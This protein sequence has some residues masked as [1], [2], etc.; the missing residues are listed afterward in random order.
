MRGG[1]LKAVVLVVVS[2]LVLMFAPMAQAAEV[3]D[4]NGPELV[5]ITR[6]TGDVVSVENPTARL[7]VQATDPNGVQWMGVWVATDSTAAP[8]EWEYSSGIEPVSVATIVRPIWSYNQYASAN[9]QPQTLTVTRV[10]LRDALGNRTVVTDRAILDPLTYRAANPAYDGDAPVLESIG[11]E[12]A[13]VRPGEEVV[14][15]AVLRDATS[16]NGGNAVLEADK[17]LETALDEVGNEVADNGDGTSTIR[18]IF[19]ARPDTP[20]GTY[21]VRIFAYDRFYN[22]LRRDP[23]VSIAVQD[24]DHPVGTVVIGGKREIG[25]TLSA[26]AEGWDPAASLSYSWTTWGREFAS[27]TTTPLGAS[28]L[29][30]DVR[31]FVTG[32]WPDGTVRTRIVWTGAIDQGVLPILPPEI[33]GPAAVDRPLTFSQQDSAMTWAPDDRR[34][35]W[36]RDGKPIQYAYAGTYV[37]SAEDFGHRISVRTFH[38]KA[39]YADLT[40]E[41]GSV[42]VGPGALKAVTPTVGGTTWRV[43][44]GLT[45]T[46]GPWAEGTEFHYQWQR[47]D[48]DIAG[49]RFPDYTP[50]A[51]DHGAQL[52]VRVTGTKPGYAQVS[53]YSGAKTVATGTIVSPA[54]SAT[55]TARVGKRLTAATTGWTGGTTLKYQ[56]QRDG[57]NIAGATGR[58][59]V[60]AAADRGKK[61]RVRVAGSNPG[62]ASVTRYTT[63]RTVGYGV[64]KSSNPTF[65]GTQRV[66]SRVTVAPGTWTT[67][68]KFT[69]QWARDGSKIRGATGRTYTIRAADRGRALSVWVTGSKPGYRSESY[70]AFVRV[71]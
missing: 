54:P 48:K 42:V 39:G 53:R 12:P 50:T 68:T 29:W 2:G 7:A 21:P 44:Q 70:E 36:L 37:P 43:G 41:S 15:T 24:P 49:A 25:H 65:S 30:V 58:T 17:F 45:A 62:Y 28:M 8:G 34:I 38:R 35:E 23:G 40:Q 5:S 64:L 13:V 52:R 9:V 10:E 27:G 22:V 4:V 55:G 66:G 57:R 59:Y 69:Y 19:R 6:T 11:V 71:R 47:N 61:I 3:A 1:P 56:W 18:T 20:Y 32:T 46:P 14:V 60:L 63:A 51:A 31:L 67:G 16:V 33:T 26:V